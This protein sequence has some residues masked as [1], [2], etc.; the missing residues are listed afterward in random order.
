MQLNNTYVLLIGKLSEATQLVAMYVLQSI[1]NVCVLIQI[2]LK[3][4]TH[5]RTRFICGLEIEYFNLL[6]HISMAIVYN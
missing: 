5:P 2:A 6:C 1:M 4:Y 3:S